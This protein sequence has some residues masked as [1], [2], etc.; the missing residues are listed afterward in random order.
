MT[1]RRITLRVEPLKGS[2]MVS[3]KLPGLHLRRRAFIGQDGQLTCLRS[4]VRVYETAVEAYRAVETLGAQLGQMY[5]DV[6][7]EWEVSLCATEVI[8]HNIFNPTKR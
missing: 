8:T 6:P 5:P 7:Q 4:E 1:K 3:A 2:Y